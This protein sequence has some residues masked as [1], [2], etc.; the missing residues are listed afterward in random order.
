MVVKKKEEDWAYVETRT[1]IPAMSGFEAKH[2][3]W[4]TAIAE[5]GFRRA[6]ATNVQIAPAIAKFDTR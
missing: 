4:S 5:V 2:G 1:P 6:P 3:D